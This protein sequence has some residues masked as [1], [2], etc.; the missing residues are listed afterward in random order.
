MWAIMLMFGPL[1]LGGIFWAIRRPRSERFYE[2]VVEGM[3]FVP[4]LAVCAGLA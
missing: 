4:A 2:W 3:L 1:Y